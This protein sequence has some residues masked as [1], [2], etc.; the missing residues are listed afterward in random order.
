MDLINRYI[1][2]VTQKSPESQRADIE[3]E[4]HGLIEDMLE[5]RGAGVGIARTEDG[6]RCRS[7]SGHPETW[8]LDIEEE[9]G[10]SLDPV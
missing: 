1:Y 7:S 10:I 4:L 5:D 3:K 9:N 8:R 2:A 6:N